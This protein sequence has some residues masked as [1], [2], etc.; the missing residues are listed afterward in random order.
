MKRLC[1]IIYDLEM[2]L[3]KPEIRRSSEEISKLLSKEFFEICSS[4]RIWY[5]N[6]NDVIDQGDDKLLVNWEIQNFQVKMLAKDVVLTTYKAIR[7][8]KKGEDVKQ[9]LRSSLWKNTN[10]KWKIVF[11]Q[12]TP[13]DKA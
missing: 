11:H 4:G 3:L 8:S 13:T 1:K 12:G 7:S 10:G 9:S 2:E 5:Y 6:A